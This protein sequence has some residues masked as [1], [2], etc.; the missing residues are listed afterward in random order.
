MSKPTIINHNLTTGEITEREMNNEEYAE[1]QSRVAE[2]E[3]AKAA[4]ADK[5]AQRQAVLNKLGL[6]ADE[7]AALIS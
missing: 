4:E 2:N 3:V 7:V 1:W 6:T 5:A